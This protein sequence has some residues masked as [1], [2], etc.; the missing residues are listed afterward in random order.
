[1][2]CLFFT[3]RN[4]LL[5]YIIYD[6]TVQK[7]NKARKELTKTFQ[8]EQLKYIQGKINKIRNSIENKQFQLVE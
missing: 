7:Y 8:K 5:L 6:I 1:M 3:T 4:C 2:C